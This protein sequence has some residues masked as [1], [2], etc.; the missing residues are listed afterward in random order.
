MSCIIGSALFATCTCTIFLILRERE[1][2]RES[3]SVCE[4]EILKLHFS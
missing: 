2:E 3:E 1:R 4:R